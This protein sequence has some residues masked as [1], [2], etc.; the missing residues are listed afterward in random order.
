MKHCAHWCSRNLSDPDLAVLEQVLYTGDFNST[1]DRQL[2]PAVVPRLHPSLLITECT[3]G[4]QIRGWRR[5]MERELLAAVRRAVEAGGKVLIPSFAVGRAQ[6]LTLDLVYC[7]NCLQ[8]C[9]DILPSLVKCCH[10]MLAQEVCAMLDDFWTAGGPTL[11]GRV[12]IFVASEMAEES[13][14]HYRTF[15]SWTKATTSGGGRHRR[16]DV[17]PPQTGSDVSC[18]SVGGEV[19]DSL[20]D[21]GGF[22]HIQPF[23]HREHWPLVLERGRPMVLFAAPGMLNG[24]LALQAFKEWCETLDFYHDAHHHCCSSCP[25]ECQ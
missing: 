16:G 1:A 24:G 14:R 12:P 18:H 19:V 7:P 8:P 22:K 11:V 25:I 4:A 9:P 10:R 21:D 20:I 5:R 15:R 3:Y 2:G 6:V 23:R 13:T 17:E